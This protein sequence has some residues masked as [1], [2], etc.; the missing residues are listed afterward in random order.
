MTELT[1]LL[2]SYLTSLG[3]EEIKLSTKKHIRRNLQAEF[4]DVLL[5]ENLLETASVFIVPANLSPLQVAKYITTIL[6]EKQDNA[7]R[8]SS[9]SA[10]IHR[11]AIDIHK[12]IQRT[13]NKMSWPPHPS[14]LAE[15]AMN[16]PKELDSF[17]QTLM[18]RKKDRPDE[19]C[20]P[21]VQSL[22]K[23]FAQ[24]LMFGVSRGKI[25][26]PK[27]ILL[28]Y[29]VKTLTNNVELIQM[30]NRCGHESPI[31]SLEKSTLPCV[32]RKWHQQV[33]SH[34][35]ITSSLVLALLWHGITLTA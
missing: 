29:A 14:D 22:M 2:R 12:A 20:H 19:D 3:V 23:S 32:F 10:N 30:L 15:R 16:V 24:D 5:F 33:K 31:H 11:A 6:L 8:Q 13:E 21:R 17:L 34:C 26:P 9:W 7:S 1:E 18:T 35:Q 28:P 4:G 27:Q 25:K